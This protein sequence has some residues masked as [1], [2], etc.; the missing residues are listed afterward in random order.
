MEYFGDTV[1][2]SWL[3]I[4][5]SYTEEDWSSNGQENTLRNDN[6]QG[7][8]EHRGLLAQGLQKYDAQGLNDSKRSQ[9]Q[10]NAMPEFPAFE[11]PSV[12]L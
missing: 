6:Y 3:D 4:R 2:P 11:D 12:S 8:G 5:N 1:D 9:H 7:H 10:V